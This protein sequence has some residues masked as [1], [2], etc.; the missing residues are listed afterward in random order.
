MEGKIWRQNGDT[1]LYPKFHFDGREEGG[2][3]EGC[4]RK[5]FYLELILWNAY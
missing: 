3:I 1:I 2:F 4:Q 5:P